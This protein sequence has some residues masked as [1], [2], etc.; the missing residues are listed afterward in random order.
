MSRSRSRERK[1]FGS[2]LLEKIA[3]LV[4]RRSRLVIGIWI[5]AVAALAVEGRDL[6][7]RLTIHPPFIDGTASER[8]HEISLRE[9]GGDD[10][11]VVMLRGPQGAVER[12]GRDLASR[13]DAMPRMLAISPWARGA[14][15]E[16]LSPSPGVAAIIVRVES[17]KEQGGADLLPSLRRQ[18]NARVS[19]PVKASLA[20]FPVVIDSLRKAGKDATALGELI[21]V[22]VLLI[23]LLL[24]F[25]SVFAALLPVIVGG[26]V[27]AATR[28]VLSLLLELIQIDLFALGIVGMMGL[29]LGVDYSLLVVSRFR[30]ELPGRN[31]PEAVR[32]TVIATARSVLPAGGGLLL[33]MLASLL[34]L[35]GGIV[36]SVVLAVV[37]ATA[38]SVISAICVVPALL[39]ALGNNLER[40]SL[41]RRRASRLAPLGWSRRLAGHRGAV[42]S[43]VVGLVLLAGWAFSLDSGAAS[44]RF[45]PPG[46]AGR[47]EQEEVEDALGP[48]WIAPMEIVVNGRGQPV[49]S[50]QRLRAM[51]AFQHRVERDP[52]VETMA[53]LAR[54]AHATKKLGGIEGELGQQERGLE[55]LG[56]GIS[57]IRAGAALNS[58][59][60]RKAAEGSRALD[61]GLGAANA[62]A[63]VLSDALQKTSTGSSRLSD[64][65]GRADKGSGQLAEG[66]T[67][68]SSGAGRLADALEQAREKTTE[69][70]GSTELLRNAMR[71]GND[72]LGE[73]QAPLQS[74]EE[75]L[76]TAWQALQRMTAGRADPEYA[77]LQSAL[78]EAELHL[79]GKDIRSGEQA[80]PSYAG[81]GS[82][83]DRAEGQFGVGLYLAARMD[84]SNRQ[85]SKGM[86][87][88]A[89]A[90]ARLDRGLQRLATGSR[91]VSDGV[92]ALARGGE[93]LSPAMQRLSQGA[94]RLSAGLG[95]LETGAGRLSSGLGTGAE[96]SEL[97]TGAL[98]RVESGLEEPATSESGLA[99][100]QQRSP[101]LFR[102]AYF[103]LASLDGSPPERRNQLV[104]L[105]NLDRGGMDAR[106]LVI[107]NDEPNSEQARETKERLEVDAERLARETG[108]EVVVGGVAPAQIDVNDALRERAPLMRIV[109]S[110]VSM[111]ILIPVMRSLTIPIL[112]ALINLITVSASFGVISLLFDGSFLGGPGFVDATVIP[113]TMM[114]MFGLA[115]DYEVFVFARIREEYLRTGS[116]SAAIKNGL[117]RTAHVVTGAAIIMI[118]VFLAFSV[119]EFMSIRNFGVAQAVAVF[120]DAFLVRLIV[121]PA[122][123]GWLGKWCWW[124]PRWLD[125]LL[126]G[127]S[128]T[129]AGRREAY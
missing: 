68:A 75:R 61:S 97:L 88:L 124:M 83:I 47:Q 118:S 33:A 56:S 90:S 77:A 62:G 122:M 27:V 12:Q 30:E 48:G 8:A 29:A 108:T 70:A 96:K 10:A 115:I 82:G 64:G 67:K 111:L 79:T 85:A 7:R 101:G 46:D 52:G 54:L 31:V 114:L 43:I 86:A 16:G 91:Q 4:T 17:D 13:L 34:V 76:V 103:I 38:L 127:G 28:G 71:S 19:S 63:G 104:S 94:Q 69:A 99:Q 55:R 100:I 129:G 41:P 22:P 60:L 51:A 23:V 95:L 59:G 15:I 112:A 57:R 39:T 14:R 125:R 107:P 72:R 80:N 128:A 58:S 9:F 45:L 123:M 11:M 65:L 92:G 35:P 5:V 6:D 53:G 66:T 93:Q 105:V 116:T 3:A 102:S 74:A 119:S 126:P 113:A 24:V 44:I 32:K 81:I 21:A 89:D 36:R 20:G 37:V 98:D 18:V 117:D 73:T 26:A 2:G 78:E 87:K 84:K 109:L 50:P 110:L 121:V 120:I 1:P 25:R 49:T 40:W 106:M 42:I